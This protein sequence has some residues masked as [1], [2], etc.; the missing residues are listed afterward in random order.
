MVEITEAENYLSDKIQEIS[1]FFFVNSDFRRCK[2]FLF[3]VGS[4]CL[5]RLVGPPTPR[6]ILDG[7]RPM[8]AASADTPF[9][10]PFETGERG[11]IHSA[12]EYTIRMPH[13]K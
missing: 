9:F 13:T 3:T 12:L 2:V 1:D 10:L 8:R 5:G 7:S 6:I 11:F 4:G